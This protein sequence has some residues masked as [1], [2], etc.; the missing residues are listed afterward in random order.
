[1]TLAGL[2][3]EPESIKSFDGTVL[4]VRRMGQGDAT[5][6]LVVNPIGANVAAWRATFVDVARERPIITWD[7]RGLYQSGPP[8][9]DRLD[10]GA[11]AEDALAGVDHHIVDRF[12]VVSWSSG[13][14]IALEIAHRYP[15]R[16][17]ALV[18]VCGGYGYNVTNAARYFEPA[19]LLPLLAGAGKHFSALLEGPLDGLMARPELAGLIR[20]SGLLA[21]SADTE[22]LV[23]ILRGMATCDLRLL[24]ATYEK[25]AGDAAPQLLSSIEAPTLLIAGERDQFTAR[26]TTEQMATAIPDAR[27]ET[28]ERATHFLPIEY[29][30]RLSDDLRAFL[31]E[32]GAG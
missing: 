16:V 9:S 14:R 23:G 21:A 18:L 4:A 27:V 15:E 29:P 6:L 8:A 32:V 10:A 30:A 19:A 2:E 25:V 26:R 1:M 3:H 17:T 24:L 28:Y 7:H 11:H 12:A 20:Q 31:V 22:A 13:T 5:P